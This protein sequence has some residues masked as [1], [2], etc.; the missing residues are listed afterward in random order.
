[1]GFPERAMKLAFS[2][3]AFGRHPLTEAIDRIAAA[4]YDGLEILADKPHAYPGELTDARI[5][6]IAAAV[7]AAGLAV[8]NVNANCTFGYWDP[9][10]PEVIFEPSLIHPDPAYRADRVRMIRR[11]IDLA[12]AVGHAPVSITSGRLQPTA[13]PPVARPWLIG[14]LAEVLAYADER[15]VRIG[16]EYEP[17]LYVEDSVDLAALIREVNHP[18][19]GANLDLGHA[20]VSGEHVPDALAALAGRI[21]NCHVEDIAGGV[22]YHLIPGEGDV[23]FGLLA[24]TLADVDYDGWLTVELYTYPDRPAEAARRSIE[25]LRR[26]WP[27][28]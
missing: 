21:W 7:R 1:V 17:G 6:E 3:N 8:S 16:I 26:I 11:A 10:P 15:D 19:L 23:D 25:F 27:A 22:H 4:G 20:I 24:A 14:H 28:Q 5:G 18:R 2:T 9:P 12:A 13:P